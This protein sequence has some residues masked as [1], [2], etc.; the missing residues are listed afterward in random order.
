MVFLFVSE[1]DTT[2]LSQKIKPSDMITVQSYG[3]KLSTHLLMWIF[4]P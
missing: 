2:Q 4:D 1:Q 3:E